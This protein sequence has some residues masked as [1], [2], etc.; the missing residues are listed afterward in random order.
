MDVIIERQGLNSWR[1]ARA[2]SDE[3]LFVIIQGRNHKLTS[4][5]SLESNALVQSFTTS[6]VVKQGI[7]DLGS[8][9]NVGISFEVSKET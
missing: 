3:S 7:R 2:F 4:E 8:R 6:P 9:V 5:R 1:S